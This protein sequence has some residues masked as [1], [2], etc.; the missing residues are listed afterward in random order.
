[1]AFILGQ[2]VA[3]ITFWEEGRRGQKLQWP[4]CKPLKIS[5]GQRLGVGHY[6]S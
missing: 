2:D 3:E 1:M 4:P 6:G 5:V